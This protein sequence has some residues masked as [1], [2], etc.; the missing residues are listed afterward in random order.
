MSVAEVLIAWVWR[1]GKTDALQECAIDLGVMLIERRVPGIPEVLFDQVMRA[2]LGG[3]DN[4]TAPVDCFSRCLSRILAVGSAFFDTYDFTVS[5]DAHIDRFRGQLGRVALRRD[6]AL[7]VPPQ[8]S[9]DR[10]V[11]QLHARVADGRVDRCPAL[12]RA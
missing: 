10:Q 8:Y 6:Q 1:V 2:V 4:A 3:L 9:L 12:C 5:D 7:G 11:Q